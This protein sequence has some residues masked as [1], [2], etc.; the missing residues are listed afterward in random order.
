M[1]SRN[2]EKD[3]VEEEEEEEETSMKSNL[4]RRTVMMRFL[5]VCLTEFAEAFTCREYKIWIFCTGQ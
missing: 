4:W 5:Q 2:Q 3:V 1:R